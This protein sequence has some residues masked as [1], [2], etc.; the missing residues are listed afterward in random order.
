MTR[1]AFVPWLLLVAA[2]VGGYLWNAGDEIA[3]IGHQSATGQASIGGPFQL[4]DQNGVP[5]SD[6]DFRGRYMLVYF[7]YTFCPDVCPTTLG[8]IADAYAKIGMRQTH[9]VPVFITLDPARDRPKTLKAYLQSF[10]PEFVGLTGSDRAIRSTAAEY[11]VYYSSHPTS[12]G[13][14]AI[15]HT[16]VAYLMDP[17]GKFVTYYD[18]NSLDPKGLAADLRRRI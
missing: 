18:E 3:A 2:T 11:R 1:L 16:G 6:R 14:Y 13:S 8:A 5:R 12:N 7:G 10:G 15:D 9:I 4:L 17:Q